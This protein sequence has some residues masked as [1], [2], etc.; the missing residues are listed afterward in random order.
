MVGPGDFHKL[1]TGLE[2]EG[3]WGETINFLMSFS[4]Q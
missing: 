3:L 1:K 4:F 2:R